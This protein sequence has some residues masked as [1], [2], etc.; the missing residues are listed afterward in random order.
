MVHESGKL[1]GSLREG[2]VDGNLAA[3]S[4]TQRQVTQ[5]HSTR[6]MGSIQPLPQLAQTSERHGCLHAY[7][8]NPTQN[9]F[10][11]SAACKAH[12][13]YRRRVVQVVKNPLANAGNR[14]AGSIPGLGRS[15][16]GGHGEY[17][18]QYSRLEN[19]TDRGA[20]QATVPR[21][22]KSQTQLK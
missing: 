17:P 15:P 20:W 8:P 7:P 11:T 10:T 6:V 19:P 16:G 5:Q 14:R 4:Q 21:V 12:F 1:Q 2:G 18:L 3:T 13:N 22:A 9:I